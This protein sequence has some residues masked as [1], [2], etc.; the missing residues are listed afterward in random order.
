M[1][2]ESQNYRMGQVQRGQ[3]WGHLVPSPC[4]SR[5]FQSWSCGYMVGLVA[6]SQMQTPPAPTLL[7]S[8]AGCATILLPGQELPTDNLAVGWLCPRISAPQW[9]PCMRTHLGFSPQAFADPEEKHRQGSGEVQAL[10]CSA[11]RWALGW[12]QSAEP[13]PPWTPGAAGVWLTRVF[14]GLARKGTGCVGPCDAPFQA[15]PAQN[16]EKWGCESMGQM[17][18]GAQLK[19]RPRS[20]YP[21]QPLCSLIPL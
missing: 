15:S 1:A 17:K 20:P 13:P 19:Q 8:C 5:I 9:D 12:L 21:S 16:K 6:G 4:S 3:P 18:R 11:P 14:A 7:H 2:Q 10:T